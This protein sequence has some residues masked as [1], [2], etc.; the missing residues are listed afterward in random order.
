[1]FVIW[2]LILWLIHFHH[3]LQSICLNHQPSIGVNR[4]K[5]S[6]KQT[7]N[8]SNSWI[9]VKTYGTNITKRAEQWRGWMRGQRLR[10][11]T[12]E[13]GKE[14]V[15]GGKT[16]GMKSRRKSSEDGFQDSACRMSLSLCDSMWTWGMSVF[17]L[18]TH[19]DSRLNPQSANVLSS[20]LMWMNA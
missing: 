15:V 12:D 10:K 9:I 19:E 4:T 7:Q 13:T 16:G 18:H 6:P 3:E 2:Y 20:P 17:I 8:T 1:M 5:L 14:M 11:E